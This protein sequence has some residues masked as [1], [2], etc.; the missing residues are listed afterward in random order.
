MFH[1]HIPVCEV[2][3]RFILF[4]YKFQPHNYYS[5]GISYSMFSYNPN[6]RCRAST[7]QV[8][9]PVGNEESLKLPPMWSGHLPS[10][11]RPSSLS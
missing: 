1:Q 6:Y 2:R 3:L 7:R 4:N 8:A 9:N 5:T 11:Y 10:M